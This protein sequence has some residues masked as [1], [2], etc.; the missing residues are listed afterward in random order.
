MLVKVSKQYIDPLVRNKN[1]IASYIILQ[2]KIFYVFF[3][4]LTLLKR[5]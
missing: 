4:I 1:K 3:F 5:S 2:T